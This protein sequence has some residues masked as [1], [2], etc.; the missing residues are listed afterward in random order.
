MAFHF[1]RYV[2]PDENWS[3]FATISA[4]S[5]LTGYEAVNL[6]NGDP[7]FPWWGATGSETVTVTLAGASEIG[8]VALI[9]S[10]TD[11][12]HNITIGGAVATT[13][14]GARG[15]GGYPRNVAYLPAPT[16]GSS[17]TLA[18][19]GN[20]IPWAIGEV[21]V[22]KLREFSWPFDRGASREIK[23]AVVIDT[24]D[25]FDHEIR[26]DNESQRWSAK[27]RLLADKAQTDEFEA[28]WESTKGGTLPMLL[29]PND[30]DDRPRLCHM[31]ASFTY[32]NEG[33]SVINFSFVECA[34]GKIVV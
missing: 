25:T 23:R 2:R 26:Y 22:G 14:V 1:P 27:G 29:I 24:D 18:I 28:L 3:R 4:T 32:T 6:K 33:H 7:S 9:H 11:S 31:D 13:I 34:R 19:A 21:V 16:T 15:A 8:I 10:N 5:E 20:S 12:G 17:V 30:V